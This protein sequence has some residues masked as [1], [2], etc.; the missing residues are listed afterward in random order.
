MA[1]TVD[2][3]IDDL[4]DKEF[5]TFR[6]TKSFNETIYFRY[7]FFNFVTKHYSRGTNIVYDQVNF[8]NFINNVI[9]LC[10]LTC[11]KEFIKQGLVLF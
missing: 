1:G 3:N 11:Q 2:F 9:S 6:K 7:Q 10:Q 4:P 8:I 5:I